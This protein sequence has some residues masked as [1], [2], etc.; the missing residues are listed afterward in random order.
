MSSD[1]ITFEPFGLG[2]DDNTTTVFD[3]YELS[4]RDL[5][6]F[7]GDVLLVTTIVGDGG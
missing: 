2:T 3:V 5:S 6:V 1:T 4:D 7:A